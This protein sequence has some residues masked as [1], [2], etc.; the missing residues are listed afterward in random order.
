M[1]IC[2]EIGTTIKKCHSGPFLASKYLNLDEEE[3][4]SVS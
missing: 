3:H 2:E 1:R 4:L